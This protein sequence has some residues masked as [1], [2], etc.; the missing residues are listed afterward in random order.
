MT[1]WLNRLKFDTHIH[2]N[3]LLTGIEDQPIAA[4]GSTYNICRLA[5]IIQKTTY[6]NIM[7]FGMESWYQIKK[8]NGKYAQ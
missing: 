5:S 8:W 7:N 4:Q 2:D 1:T 3:K 6:F